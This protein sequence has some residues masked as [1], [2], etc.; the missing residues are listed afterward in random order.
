M[1]QE[2][3]VGIFG[4][5]EGFKKKKKNEISYINILRSI[6]RIMPFPELNRNDGFRQFRG[7]PVLLDIYFWTPLPS[8][9]Y[10]KKEM[11][12]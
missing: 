7:V 11:E 3:F 12:L 1:S 10:T 9:Y 2:K 4:L 5:I 6:I 8:S